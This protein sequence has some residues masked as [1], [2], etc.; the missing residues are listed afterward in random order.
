MYSQE[1]AEEEV[2]RFINSVIVP[3][4]TNLSTEAIVS[5]YSPKPLF[6]LSHLED[7]TSNKISKEITIIT[8]IL[9]YI[10][11]EH[12]K[13]K[14]YMTYLETEKQ[15]SDDINKDLYSQVLNLKSQLN[16]MNEKL[17][18]LEKRSNV[19]HRTDFDNFTGTNIWKI[20]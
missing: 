16:N 2:Q 20:L 9:V 13:L 8:D 18:L 7:D 5:M 14:K 6:D 1:S 11:D 10:K 15:K 19:T 12:I 4:L 17:L 3:N